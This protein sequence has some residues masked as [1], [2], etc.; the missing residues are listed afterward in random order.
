MIVAAFFLAACGGI[1]AA[2]LFCK[3]AWGDGHEG[4]CGGRYDTYDSFMTEGEQVGREREGRVA[5]GPEVVRATIQT[6]QYTADLLNTRS[7][8]LFRRRTPE[9][10][11]FFGG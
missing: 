8:V 9:F 5:Y 3:G 10:G 11:K 1:I 7:L 4:I 6:A 2:S